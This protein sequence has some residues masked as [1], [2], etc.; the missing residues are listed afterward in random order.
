MDGIS[1]DEAGPED[2]G[3]EVEGDEPV[4]GEGVERIQL[5]KEDEFVRKLLDPKLPSKE[6]IK[7]HELKGH[8]DYRNW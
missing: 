1:E 6:D 3:I 2:V 7:I 4:G 8:V 5:E